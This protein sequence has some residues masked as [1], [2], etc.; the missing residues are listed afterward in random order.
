MTYFLRYCLEINM[1]KA[2]A[3]PMHRHDNLNY[4]QLEFVGLMTAYP[5]ANVI[6]NLIIL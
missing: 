5:L 2:L 3:E 1:F 6:F 4:Y